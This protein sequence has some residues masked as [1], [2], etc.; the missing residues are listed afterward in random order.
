M[1]LFLLLA[2][3]GLSLFIFTQTG[4]NMLKPYIKQELEEKIGLPVEIKTFTF[5]SGTSSL[6]FLINKQAAVKVVSQYNLW[7][8]SFEGIYHIKAD[9]FT[10]EDMQFE[11]ADIKGNFK[12]VSEDIYVDGKGTALDAKVDYRLNVIDNVAQKIIL[13]MKGADLSEVL[14]LSFDFHL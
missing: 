9:K 8:Q 7:D 12:G 4:N 6:D 14:R 3:S 11:E 2:I 10:Y 13:N 5:D 1:L